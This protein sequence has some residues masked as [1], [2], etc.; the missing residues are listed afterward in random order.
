MVKIIKKVNPYQAYTKS[1]QKLNTK[2]CG[3]SFCKRLG[4]MFMF[5]KPVNLL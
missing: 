2:T 1:Y 3:E 5:A 4:I